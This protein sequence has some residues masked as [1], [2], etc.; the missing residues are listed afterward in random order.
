M[1]VRDTLAGIIERLKES[2]TVETVFGQPVE[3]EGK[4][5][6]SVAKARY[7]FGAGVGEGKSNYATLEGESDSG[8]WAAAASMIGSSGGEEL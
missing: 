4:T 3:F 5:V 1:N 2:A 8:E 6:I 7:G